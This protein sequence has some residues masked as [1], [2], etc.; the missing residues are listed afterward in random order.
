MLSCVH[1]RCEG[2]S[3]ARNTG[4][5]MMM[6]GVALGDT[7]R[8]FL[9]DDESLSPKPLEG[10]GK[11]KVSFLMDKGG[12]MPLRKVVPK[13]WRGGAGALTPHLCKGADGRQSPPASGR[14]PSCAPLLRDSTSLSA[15]RG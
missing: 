9:T 14:T 2:T 15:S 5:G 7:P 12:R 13:S 10:Q 11:S 3:S 1:C 4:V 6:V 8:C